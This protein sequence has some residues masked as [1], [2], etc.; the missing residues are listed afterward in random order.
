[1]TVTKISQIPYHFFYFVFPC[2]LILELF[3]IISVMRTV[4]QSPVTPKSHEYHHCI[5]P[6]T[7]YVTGN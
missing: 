2:V 1:M 6:L 5:Y 7:L 3:I 4:R